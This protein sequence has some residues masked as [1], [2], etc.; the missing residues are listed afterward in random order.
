MKTAVVALLLL[1]ALPTAS[2]PAWTMREYID[3]KQQGSAGNEKLNNYLV[4]V[5]DAI[6]MS[7][8]EIV[9]N[10]QTPIFCQG[11]RDIS[12]DMIRAI[13]DRWVQKTEP[14][15]TPADWKVF[16]GKQNLAGAVLYSLKGAMPCR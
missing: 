12:V 11:Q 2:S 8:E 15:K 6:G 9:A 16:V 5:I 4:A 10:R 7:N 3:L 14:T 13:L 1:A